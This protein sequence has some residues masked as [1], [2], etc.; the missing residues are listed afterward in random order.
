[1]GETDPIIGFGS[2]PYAY[3]LAKAGYEV[4]LMD[5][6]DL[7]TEQAKEA[8][9]QQPEHPIVSISLGDARAPRFSTMS[10]DAVLLLGPPYHLDVGCAE[11]LS[12]VKVINNV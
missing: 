5:P 2:E 3:W 8:S 10:A 1:M 9:N 6:V 4:H 7:H 12:A 11:G